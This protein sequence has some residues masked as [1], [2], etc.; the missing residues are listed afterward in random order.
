MYGLINIG[1]KRNVIVC[2]LP[3]YTQVSNK[4]HELEDKVKAIDQLEESFFREQQNV[5][6]VVLRNEELDLEKQKVVS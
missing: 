5:R 4:E 1:W 2:W 3:A 6:T